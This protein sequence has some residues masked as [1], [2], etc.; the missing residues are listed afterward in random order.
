MLVRLLAAA[1]A[2]AA[3]TASSLGSGDAVTAAF[4]LLC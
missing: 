3:E 1:H 4:N 2:A